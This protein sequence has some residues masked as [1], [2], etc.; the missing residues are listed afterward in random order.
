[1]FSSTQDPSPPF[2][3]PPTLR[4]SDLNTTS[5][6]Q[7]LDFNLLQPTQTKMSSPHVPVPAGGPAFVMRAVNQLVDRFWA[8]SLKQIRKGRIEVVVP[9]EIAYALGQAGV[10]RVA[11]RF[12]EHVKAPVEKTVDAEQKVLRILPPPELRTVQPSEVNAPSAVDKN[13]T[14][15]KPPAT[16]EA[17]STRTRVLDATSRP[18]KPKVPRPCNPFIMYR[19]FLHQRVTME[20]PGLHNNQI[21]KNFTCSAQQLTLTMLSAKIIGKMWQEESPEA[22]EFWRE[23]AKLGKEEHH[24]RFPDYQYRPRKPGEKKRR[25]TKK[26][27]AEAAAAAANRPSISDEPLTFDPPTSLPISSGQTAAY[28]VDPHQKYQGYDLDPSATGRQMFQTTLSHHTGFPTAPTNNPLVTL[29]S[30]AATDQDAYEATL[31]SV[32]LQQQAEAMDVAEKQLRH[33]LLDNFGF[34]VQSATDQSFVEHSF[35]AAADREV[36]FSAEPMNEGFNFPLGDLN[37]DFLGGTELDFGDI[38]DI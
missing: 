21:C 30:N 29:S 6:Q 9:F 16:I 32:G 36:S 22:K 2:Q 25:M 8:E 26:K 11:Q 10:D 27:L 38:N 20:N 35:N 28:L 37:Y 23:R 19:N 18:S 3:Q 31:D 5:T 17:K 15:A 7:P 12:S 33:A 13:A 1:M 24:L 14:P 4:P 34:S